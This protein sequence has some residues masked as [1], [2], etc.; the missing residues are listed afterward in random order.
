[1]WAALSLSILIGTWQYDGFFYEGQRYPNP[2]PSLVLT[3]DFLGNGESHLQWHREGEP[4]FCERRALYRVEN[5][6]LFQKVFWINPKN[7]ADCAK[8]PDMQPDDETETRFE[9]Q[10]GELHFFFD[11]NGKEFIYI[12]KRTLP[13][14]LPI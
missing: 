2:N 1:M 11:L 3:F 5:D 12:L 4:G 10:N 6:L 9:I 7:A 8:D 14:P 13:P